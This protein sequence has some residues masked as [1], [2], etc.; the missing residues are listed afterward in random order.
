MQGKEGRRGKGHI[1]MFV[2]CTGGGGVHSEECKVW[3]LLML[4]N[5]LSSGM[6][7]FIYIEYIF[8]LY[9]NDVGHYRFIW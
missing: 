3:R 2:S 9:E 1:N 5:V 6:L 8:I 4:R 7:I